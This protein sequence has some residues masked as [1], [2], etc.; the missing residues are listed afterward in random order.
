MFTN[1]FNTLIE[2]NTLKPLN[3]DSKIEKSSIISIN[4]SIKSNYNDI[5][6]KLEKN[7]E[8]KI[9]IFKKGLFTRVL[10]NIDLTK[11]KEIFIKYSLYN[12]T[13]KD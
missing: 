5:S 10:L 6:Y 12:Y 8:S 9:Y 1:N 7:T 11:E 3:I 2:F 13:K 4:N